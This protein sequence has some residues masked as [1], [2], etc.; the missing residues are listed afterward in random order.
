MNRCY[1]MGR[2]A[3]EWKGRTIGDRWSRVSSATTRG[4]CRPSLKSILVSGKSARVGSRGSEKEG[5]PKA[6]V[7]EI[8]Q[9]YSEREPGKTISD[10]GIG[11]IVRGRFSFFILSLRD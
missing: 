10:A 4:N 6:E 11:N 9:E 2:R 8:D 1:G 3:S 5:I 7:E